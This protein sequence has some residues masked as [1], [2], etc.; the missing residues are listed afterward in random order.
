MAFDFIFG[1]L[2]PAVMIVSGWIMLVHPPAE[3]N[4]I[5]GYRT[6]MSMKNQRTW[7]FAHRMA[8]KTWL[9]LGAVLLPLSAAALMI[10][11]KNSNES[12]LTLVIVQLLFLCLSILP[13]EIALRRNFD[14]SGAPKE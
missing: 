4:D 14:K 1:L 10:F 11:R 2:I 3:I 12:L 9:V 8:G 6:K 5:F 7:Q 13:V